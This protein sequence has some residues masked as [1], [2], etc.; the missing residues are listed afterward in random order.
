VLAVALAVAV[1]SLSHAEVVSD[2]RV[3]TPNATLEPGASYVTGTESLK[4]DPRARC[5]LGG[6]GGSGDRVKLPGPT[7]LG[8]VKSAL[9]WNPALDPISVTDEFGF[10]LGVCGFGGRQGNENRYWALFVNY[11][12]PGLGGDQVRL[13]DG[14]SALWYL[15]KY[16]PPPLLELTAP[17]G[18][19]TG[20]VPVH[21]VAHQCTTGGPPA[22]QTVCDA[23]PVEGA[24]VTGGP[25]SASTDT[26]GDATVSLGQPGR[27]DLQASLDPD[28]P[29]ETV[30]VCVNDD[31]A[32]CPDAHGSTIYGRRGDDRFGGT[33][34]WDAIRAGG[35][36]DEVDLSAGGRDRVSCGAGHDRVTGAA[37]DDAIGASCERVVNG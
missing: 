1:P 31:L 12:D 28:V 32:Q 20:G 10:G 27:Y 14:D 23:T 15:T 7:A 3:L 8:L 11:E 22:Y 37:S 6:V 2:L 19:T 29:S 13:H 18:A 24:T 30:E 36:D 16:P 33:P 21:V 34:G 5:F 26:N 25:T 35:G 17:A 4:T 9:S